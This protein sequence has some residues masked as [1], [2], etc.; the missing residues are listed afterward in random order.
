MNDTGD[1]I[2]KGQTVT[3]AALSAGAGSTLATLVLSWIT[4]GRCHTQQSI[5]RSEHLET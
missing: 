2:P 3:S 4:P 5:S 1:P